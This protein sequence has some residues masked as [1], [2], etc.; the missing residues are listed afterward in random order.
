MKRRKIGRKAAKTRTARKP[1]RRQAVAPQDTTSAQIARER[2]EALL[3]QAATAE[4]LK[5][6]S[7][8]PTDTQ[9]V[10]DVIVQSGLKIFP[11]GDTLQAVAFAATDPTR[12]DMWRKRW[13]IPLSRE[14]MHSLAFLDRKTVD[15]P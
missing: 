13:P 10:F 14:Y 9:P 15:I 5:L 1:V 7:A 4:I 11:D 6:I 2:D 3:Q 12:A 8:S